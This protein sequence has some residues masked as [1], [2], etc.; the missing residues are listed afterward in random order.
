M[1]NSNALRLGTIWLALCA[2]LLFSSPCVGQPAQPGKIEYNT[3]RPGMDFKSI[4]F[5][6][7]PYGDCGRR[8]Q[9]DPRC[10]AWTSCLDRQSET[11]RCYLKSGVPPKVGNQDCH[12][13]AKNPEITKPGSR[14]ASSFRLLRDASTCNTLAGFV[15]ASPLPTTGV[16]WD[17]NVQ[18]QATGG[19]PPVRFLTPYLD[20][21]TGVQEALSC[22]S[23]GP[24][25]GPAYYS[26]K[27]MVDGLTLTCDGRIIGQPKA[28]GYFTVSIV[29]TDQC[30]SP[31]KVEKTFVLEVK[32]PS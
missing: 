13:G 29:A 15:T 7:W 10:Q 20:P 2:V 17:Y 11:S 24:T 3:D 14:S 32:G 8:C 25:S 1:E 5:E 31:Q 22:N 4:D 6:G 30:V 23:G 12:S 21:A 26:G 19:V 16:G 9:E 28:P 18:L 27:M